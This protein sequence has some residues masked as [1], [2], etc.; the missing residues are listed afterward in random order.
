M[1]TRQG[2]TDLLI[3]YDRLVRELE[4]LEKK[5]VKKIRQLIATKEKI[6]KKRKD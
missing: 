1:N 5:R 6:D 4:V 3:R 2:R